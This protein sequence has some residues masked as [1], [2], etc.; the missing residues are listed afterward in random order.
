MEYHK[1]AKVYYHSY[2][3]EIDVDEN[4]AELLTRMWHE[5]IE[6]IMSCG[7]NNND[8]TLIE[9]YSI[10]DVKKF[11]SI[12]FSGVDKNLPIYK[13][14]FKYNVKNKWVFSIDYDDYNNYFKYD[15]VNENIKKINSVNLK[16]SGIVGFPVQDYDFVL[17][18]FREINE[19]RGLKPYVCDANITYSDEKFKNYRYIFN[20]KNDRINKIINREFKFLDSYVIEEHIYV[21]RETLYITKQNI[22][23]IH[24][25]DR[26][27]SIENLK[28]GV[29]NINYDILNYQYE[30]FNCAYVDDVSRC[31]PADNIKINKINLK[32][33]DIIF[34]LCLTQCDREFNLKD[35]EPL[36]SLISIS[37]QSE[38]I[39]IDIRKI[40]M[41][42]EIEITTIKIYD[43]DE[44]KYYVIGIYIKPVKV[45]HNNICMCDKCFDFLIK[46]TEQSII[47]EHESLK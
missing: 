32:N 30:L 27:S 41:S 9:F 31:I 28:I 46:S 40:F 25:F 29:W 10:V 22:S 8:Y 17:K 26:F 33:D 12:V 35:L 44:D 18:K 39:F 43:E 15:N 1:Q 6:T 37:K 14:A 34:K 21:N 19:K 47:Y 42:D 45:V 4:I 36:N 16:C 7:D 5:S 13:R 3:E 2:D 23:N 11:L 24:I 38:N 20:D